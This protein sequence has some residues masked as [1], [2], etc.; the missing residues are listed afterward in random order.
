LRVQG[1]FFIRH[2]E[3]PYESHSDLFVM[4]FG[5]ERLAYAPALFSRSCLML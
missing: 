2:S 4:T 5:G 3:Q 1:L